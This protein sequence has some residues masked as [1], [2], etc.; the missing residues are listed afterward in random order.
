MNILGIE[1]S[2]D[3]TA[4]SV[5]SS[6]R[7]LRSNIIWSQADLHKQFG[8][9]VPEIAARKHIEAIVPTVREALRVA[10]MSLEDID[11]IAVTAGPG[12]I[13]AL[14]VGVSYAKA[15]AAASNLPLIPVHHITGHVAANYIQFPELEPPFVCLIASGGHSH[16]VSVDDYA[17]FRLLARTRD[18]AAGEAFDKISRALGLGYPGGPLIDKAAETGDPHKYKFP[19]T[20]FPDGSL[21]F[22]F[23][24]LKTA[25]L[26]FINQKQIKTDKMALE[27]G[28]HSQE[29]ADFAAS[30]QYAIVDVLSERAVQA[31]LAEGSKRLALAGGVAANR[32]LRRLLTERC[33][34][35]GIEFYVPPAVLCTDNAA[36]IASMAYYLEALDDYGQLDAKASVALPVKE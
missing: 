28:R 12:L 17:S 26:N 14:L 25:A 18:D 11:A 34:E 20:V 21:D 1:T 8:G 30:Y 27:E 35:H 9:V 2:C 31:C 23:S 15:L 5:V 36:M 22:S 6:G 24:G 33:A 10:E 7:I 32:A 29:V 3:E 4:A 19:K 16:I 13:G